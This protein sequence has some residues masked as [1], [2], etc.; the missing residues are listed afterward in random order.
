MRHTKPHVCNTSGC[1][2]KFSSKYDLNRRQQRYH[3]RDELFSSVANAAASMLKTRAL[4]RHFTEG[5]PRSAPQTKESPSSPSS[6]TSTSGSVATSAARKKIRR[7]ADV[8]P[9]SSETSA[10]AW[11]LEAQFEHLSKKV[12]ELEDE[13][14][15]LKGELERAN[16][17]GD[18]AREEKELWMKAMKEMLERK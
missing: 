18:K 2:Q 7:V 9:G 17:E 11:N 4:E 15:R 5:Q 16:T 8:T 14:S 10:T 13:N 6:V 3:Q 12:K 1:D